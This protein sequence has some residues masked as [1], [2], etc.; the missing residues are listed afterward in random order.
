MSLFQAFERSGIFLAAL[1]PRLLNVQNRTGSS[2]AIDSDRDTSTALVLTD[3]V[4]TRWLHINRLDLELA[5]F[6]AQWQQAIAPTETQEVRELSDTTS[7]LGAMEFSDN[8]E[9]S[10]FPPGALSARKR[11]EKGRKM[12]VAAAAILLVLLLA[13]IPFIGQSLE[14]RRWASSLEANRDMALDARQD[15]ASV[16]NFENE[17]GSI[18]DFPEQ[19]VRE[20]MYTLQNVLN[21]DQLTSLELEQG[22]IKIQGTSTDPQ[23]LLQRLEQDPMFTEVVFARATNNT[24]YYIDLRLST[25]NFEGYMV[26]YFPDD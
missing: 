18:N 6:A 16:V 22:L 13:S 19:R 9:Y 14:F 2:I 10:F 8:Q 26:R 24:R 7:Y 21:P 17:W 15:Q 23:A 12:L 5:E 20:A 11:V 25:V 4:I 3:N 1:R